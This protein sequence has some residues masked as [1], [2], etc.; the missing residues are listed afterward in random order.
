MR[1]RKSSGF[2]LVELLVVIAIIGVLVGLLLPAVQA[3]REAA[4]RMSCGNNLKQ[5]SLALQNYHDTYKVFPHG[6]ESVSGGWGSNWRVRILPFCEQGALYDLWQFGPTHGWAGGA[7]RGTANLNSQLGFN[8]EWANCPST[9]LDLYVPP[10]GDVGG[11]APERLIN[12]S[13]F[14]V[15]GAE[16]SPNGLWVSTK[17]NDGGAV[18]GIY[19]ADGMLPVNETLSMAKCTDG[20]S[21]TLI[22]AEISDFVFDAAKTTKADRRPGATWGWMMGTNNGNR[23]ASVDAVAS[24][25]TI[26]YPPNSNMLNQSGVNN[27]ENDRRNTPLSSAHPGGLQVAAVDGHVQFIA[28]TID[29]NTLTY[30]SVRDDGQVIPSF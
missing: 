30:L 12:F 27:G 25:T 16:N 20:T 18:K 5:I 11:G 21:N 23:G 28:S 13:Y 24:T 1:V 29:M 4:R 6:D 2:T 10:R 3:A 17:R 15:A 14:G 8:P 19:T 22:I 7:P 9:P 26:R